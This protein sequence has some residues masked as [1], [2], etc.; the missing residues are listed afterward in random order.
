MQVVT[1]V[2]V[3]LGAIGTAYLVV[4]ERSRRAEEVRS[5]KS[6]AIVVTYEHR[7]SSQPGH[8]RYD[9]VIENIGK[10][11]A[12]DVDLL[13]FNSR[14]DGTNGREIIK[15]RGLLPIRRLSPGARVSL[16]AIPSWGSAQAW[17]VGVNGA[18]TSAGTSSMI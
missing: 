3:V 14:D 12:R 1:L 9:V 18:T 4:I 6:A 15:D 17:H 16:M 5:R 8:G 2:V 11:E 7:A 10:C 13:R